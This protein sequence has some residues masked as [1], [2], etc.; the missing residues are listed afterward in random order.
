VLARSLF[1]ADDP[2]TLGQA[3]WLVCPDLRPS[4]EVFDAIADAWER[5]RHIR[6]VPWD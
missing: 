6:D 5:Y 1:E 2:A 4:G 3:V